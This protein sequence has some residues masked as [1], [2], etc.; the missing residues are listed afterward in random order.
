M[1]LEINKPGGT[2]VDDMQQTGRVI[3]GNREPGKA[4]LV[5]TSTW[6]KVTS[7][8][9]KAMDTAVIRG[10]TE[11]DFN[12]MEPAERIGYR[13]KVDDDPNSPDY[14]VVLKEH[15][16][17]CITEIEKNADPK[18]ADSLK[19]KVIAHTNEAVGHID[20]MA[21]TKTRVPS[22]VDRYC[23]YLGEGFTAPILASHLR[24]SGVDAVHHEAARIMVTDSN[25]GDATP[26]ISGT[27]QR[28][29]ES[30]LITNLMRGQVVVMEGYGGADKDGRITTFSRGGS[31]RTA[32]AM[33]Q[34]LTVYFDPITVCLYK[35][36]KDIAGI[37]S[38]DPKMV[39]G[40]HSVNHMHYLEA[41]TL[42][43]MGGNIL[44]SKAVDHAIRSGSSKRSPF[45]IY[46]KSTAIPELPGT[47]IDNQF[48]TNEPSI[49]VISALT[50]VIS[51]RIGGMGM[52][53]PGIVSATSN[54]LAMA[55]IDIAFIDQSSP[56][57]LLFAY[58]YQGKEEGVALE[59]ML[60]KQSRI[61][62]QIAKEALGGNIG[63][64]DIDSIS[65]Q[66]ASLVGVIGYGAARFFNLD[67]VFN[68]LDGE[69]F[70]E[71]KQPDS[72][73]IATNPWGVS[74]LFN[75]RTG[76]IAQ[77]DEDFKSRLIHREALIKAFIQSAHDTF[78][79]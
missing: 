35:A 60:E 79:R 38:A 40:A 29:K 65:A 5:V 50:K 27:R 26:I 16:E 49:K 44:H 7:C 24:Y 47:L 72:Y 13:R 3:A 78:F 11:A 55:G 2:S 22:I 76:K 12:K 61:T 51:L 37:M 46:V 4:L 54:A 28:S 70:D 69:E 71:L 36:D 34:A 57:D 1:K 23:F 63:T 6:S 18:E 75:L 17:R 48:L 14:W 33:G 56:L 59:K 10:V 32:T 64:A 9:Q 25:F 74:V 41:S 31:D 58:Q 39:K 15:F 43:T 20:A 52:E 62:E 67:T 73:R 30:G 53:K 19:A 68:R 45:P 8:L 42:A 77:S 21:R 66:P